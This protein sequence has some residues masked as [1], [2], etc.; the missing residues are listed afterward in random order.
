MVRTHLSNRNSDW[1]NQ[2]NLFVMDECLGYSLDLGR[3]SSMLGHCLDLHRL[4][5][6]PFYQTRTDTSSQGMDD[7]KLRGNICV[8]IVSMDYRVA[9]NS[10]SW[11]F[12]RTGANSP[13]GILGH[14]VIR[15]EPDSSVD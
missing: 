10:K 4:H 6:I 8:C 1:S 13:V 5:G 14:T 9:C 7:Q 2:C 11:K 3:Q 15:N 12:Y